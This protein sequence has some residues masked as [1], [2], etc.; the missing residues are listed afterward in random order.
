MHKQR[1]ALIRFA[2]SLRMEIYSRDVGPPF[3]RFWF[4]SST[5]IYVRI[6]KCIVSSAYGSCKLLIVD[7][8]IKST[9]E[10]EKEPQQQQQ[11]HRT[12]FAWLFRGF[13]IGAHFP[14]ALSVP[15][16][17]YQQTWYT[18]QQDTQRT[19]THHAIQMYGESTR[20]KRLIHVKF[21]EQ[22]KHV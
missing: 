11:Q 4:D 6:E 15:H 21:V 14:G 19:F 7:E 9:A 13:W 12:F 17:S 5:S 18:V 1:S 22:V 3:N 20:H 16:Q 2:F 8:Y 10:K